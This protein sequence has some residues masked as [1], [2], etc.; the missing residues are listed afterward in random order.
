MTVIQ[1][2]YVFQN[3]NL[4]KMR[5]FNLQLKVAKIDMCWPNLFFIYLLLFYSKFTGH[6]SV[7]IT[8]HL[9]LTSELMDRCF[10]CALFSVYVTHSKAAEIWRENRLISICVLIS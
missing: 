10:S 8:F 1:H 2:P 4:N 9:S 6:S 7:Q 5:A 3:A